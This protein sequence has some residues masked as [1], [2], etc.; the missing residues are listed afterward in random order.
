[1]MEY[2]FSIRKIN[3]KNIVSVLIINLVVSKIFEEIDVESF[4]INNNKEYSEPYKRKNYKTNFENCLHLLDTYIGK[5][6]ILKI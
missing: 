2:F 5:I 6:L 3:T 1:M 4:N